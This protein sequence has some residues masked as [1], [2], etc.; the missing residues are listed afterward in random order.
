MLVKQRRDASAVK[1]LYNCFFK[2]IIPVF[3]TLPIKLKTK[4]IVLEIA[5]HKMKSFLLERMEGELDQP[6]MGKM[7]EKLSF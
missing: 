4:N 7:L 3:N 2:S 5:K 1:G 6:N